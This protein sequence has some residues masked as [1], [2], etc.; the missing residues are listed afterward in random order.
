MRR[1]SAFEQA[2]A[3]AISENETI[4]IALLNQ[5]SEKRRLKCERQGK[6]EG[7][8]ASLFFQERLPPADNA[9]QLSLF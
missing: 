3:K 8:L 2:T 9:P 6:A 4:G 7:P 5:E 1:H